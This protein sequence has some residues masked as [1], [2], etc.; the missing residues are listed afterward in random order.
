M[1][2]DKETVTRVGLAILNIHA[3][4]LCRSVKP[5]HCKTLTLYVEQNV[6]FCTLPARISKNCRA[7]YLR[8]SI[9]VNIALWIYG[10]AAQI[11]E[12]YHS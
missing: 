3:H 1:L 6:C 8:A 10:S 2:Y 11:G 12:I 5:T 7:H 9:Y 4:V